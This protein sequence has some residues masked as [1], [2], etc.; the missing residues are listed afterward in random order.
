MYITM[1]C[2]VNLNTQ[3]PLCA[4]VTILKK[5]ANEMLQII[6]SFSSMLHSQE[7]NTQYQDHKQRHTE[8]VHGHFKAL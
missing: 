3:Q 5:N 7:V 2:A 4:L 8:A 6:T 1:K